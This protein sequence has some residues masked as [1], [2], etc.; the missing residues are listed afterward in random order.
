[1][2]F[3]TFRGTNHDFVYC[4][5]STINSRLNQEGGWPLLGREEEAAVVA[6]IQTVA[7]T[8]STK[9]RKTRVLCDKMCCKQTRVNVAQTTEEVINTNPVLYFTFYPKHF[10]FEEILMRRSKG[11][12]Q[13]KYTKTCHF[14]LSMSQKEVNFQFLNN[15]QL[16]R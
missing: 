15:F 13:D 6:P 12:T 10:H 1:M 8:K 4:S 2:L 14:V 11:G 3:F 16:A 5:H 7:A 9:K